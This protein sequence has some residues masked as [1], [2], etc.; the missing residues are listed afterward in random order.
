MNQALNRVKESQQKQMKVIQA[1]LYRAEKN[2][3]RIA[4]RSLKEE[5]IEKNLRDKNQERTEMIKMTN[6]EKMAN[7]LKRKQ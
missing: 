2:N 3:I 1:S 5:R 4:V 7:V 6:E